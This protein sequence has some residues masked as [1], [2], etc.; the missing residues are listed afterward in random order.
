VFYLGSGIGIYAF[1]RLHDA[2]GNYQVALWSAAGVLLT[3]AI[4]LVLLP[5]YRFR[6]GAADG[7]PVVAASP[8]PQHV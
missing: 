1:G 7:Q 6:A 4:V 2:Y 5:Q 8:A 3:S